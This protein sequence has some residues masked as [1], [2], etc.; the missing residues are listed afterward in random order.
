MSPLL[1]TRTK[2]INR[3]FIN[4]LASNGAR[5]SVKDDNNF[6]LTV[7]IVCSLIVVFA[8]LVSK[9]IFK[10]LAIQALKL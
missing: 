4:S 10:F 5:G 7:L 3:S 9:L 8:K 2:R 6:F 1:K